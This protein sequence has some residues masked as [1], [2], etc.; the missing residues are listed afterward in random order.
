MSLPVPSWSF[1]SILCYVGPFLC[2]LGPP[3]LFLGPAGCLC[4]PK[5]SENELETGVLALQ[6]VAGH[7]QKNA[8][9]AFHPLMVPTQLNLKGSWVPG[10]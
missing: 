2:M 9:V 10:T 7:N 4:S 5:P 3:K 1:C 6:L 8:F